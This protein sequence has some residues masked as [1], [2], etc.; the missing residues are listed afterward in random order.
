MIVQFLIVEIHVDRSA[1]ERLQLLR[2]A[3][4]IDVR[5]RDNYR[6]HSQMMLL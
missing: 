4:V 3:D 6:L 2:A 5:V 1:G